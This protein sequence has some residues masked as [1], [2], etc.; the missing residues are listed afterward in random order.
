M[1]ERIAT[2]PR[3]TL[4]D[5]L[6]EMRQ[7]IRKQTVKDLIADKLSSLIASGVLAV[8]DELPGERE[9]S[10]ILSVSR[11]T[12]RGAIQTL[13][14]RGLVD[15][16]HGS[17]TR[18]AHVDLGSL[19]NGLT[20]ASTI[21]RYDIESVHGARLLV[22]RNVVAAAAERI[23]AEA[24]RALEESLAAQA[25]MLGDPVQFLI[26][27]REFHV[28]IYRAAG[29]RLLADFVIDLYTYLMEFRRQAMARPGAIEKSFADHKA[30]VAALHARDVAAVVAAFDRHIDRI[31]ATTRS[32]LEPAAR[33]EKRPGLQKPARRAAQPEESL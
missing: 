17:R 3:E 2:R 29:N 31:Y 7:S 18:V 16:A 25:T 21:N 14:G 33:G 20:N 22:E 5:R 24:L 11:E 23:D 26:A 8:G 30:I 19:Q 10:A 28:T 13:A 15:V 27:D 12:I 32:I 6:P 1:Q 9:L 4:H